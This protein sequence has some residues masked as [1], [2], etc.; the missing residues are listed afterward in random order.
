VNAKN[1]GR[2]GVA[3]NVIRVARFAIKTKDRMAVAL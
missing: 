3:A 2:F 1:L